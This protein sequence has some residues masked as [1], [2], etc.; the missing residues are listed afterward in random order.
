MKKALRKLQA[1][2]TY[3]DHRLRFLKKYTYE[4]GVDDLVRY[5]A[6]QYVVEFRELFI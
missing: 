2:K 3:N 6:D 5:G 1:A 4:L